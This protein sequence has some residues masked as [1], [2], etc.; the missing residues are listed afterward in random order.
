MAATLAA[1]TL[2]PDAAHA[3]RKSPLEG[4]P[5]VVR[6]QG[7]LQFQWIMRGYNKPHLLNI[8]ECSK[9]VGQDHMSC[10]DWVERA[11]E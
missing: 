1:V 11:K 7:L 10:V 6:K 3:K 9:V 5:V 2:L 8:C 4:K